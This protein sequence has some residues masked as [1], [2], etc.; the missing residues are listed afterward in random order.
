MFFPTSPPAVATPP[1]IMPDWEQV[2]LDDDPKLAIDLGTIKDF[3]NIPREDTFFDAEKT[4]M[5][6]VAQRVIEQYCQLTLLSS[7]W[8]G[9]LSQ[10]F[11]FIRI[12]KRPFNAVT[13]I[14]Y[15]DATTGVVTT[16]DPTTYVAAKTKQFCGYVA[17]GDGV[18]W[19]DA[20]NRADGVRI[21]ITVGF[22]L[23]NPKYYDLQQALL[24]TIAAVDKA[25]AD[26]SGGGA[27]RQSIF[28]MKHPAAMGAYSIIPATAKALLS[29]YRLISVV[30]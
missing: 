30:A 18:E 13:G 25:R 4:A 7:T 21:T 1:V 5:T 22:D 6:M 20:A 15:V 2:V 19:P 17:R 11:D 10:F 9:N 24:I 28:A 3:L 26:E 27:G 8:V 14:Q 16:V 29:P 23:T 12:N